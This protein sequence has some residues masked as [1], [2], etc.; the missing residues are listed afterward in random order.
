MMCFTVSKVK[1]RAAPR[2]IVSFSSKC[3]NSVIDPRPRR[4]VFM[5]KEYMAAPAMTPSAQLA[6]LPEWKVTPRR[7]TSVAPR[8][9]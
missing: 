2:C 9:P 4:T 3:H 6:H 5:S 1:G 7:D 8:R